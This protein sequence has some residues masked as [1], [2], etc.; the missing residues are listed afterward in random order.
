MDLEAVKKWISQGAQP[1]DTA[2]VLFKKQG[3]EGMEKFIEPRNKKHKSKSE[4]AEAPAAAPQAAAPA[5]APAEA[6]KAEEP[7]AA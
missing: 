3:M 4:P 5:E 6:P 1:S 7:K 2:A